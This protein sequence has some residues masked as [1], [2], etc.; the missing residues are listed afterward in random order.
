MTL[1]ATSRETATCGP[2]GQALMPCREGCIP[3]NCGGWVHVLTLFHDCLS[4][5]G[6]AW[7]AETEAR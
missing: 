2:C 7:P 5:A 6:T 3:H 1:E 4:G